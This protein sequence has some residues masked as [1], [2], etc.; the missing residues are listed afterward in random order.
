MLKKSMYQ[1][2]LERIGDVVNS[3]QSISD[4]E[5][6]E[7]K[8]D[9]LLN[10]SYE[11]IEN[12]TEIIS[13]VKAAAMTKA[14]DIHDTKAGFVYDLEALGHKV[15]VETGAF[16]RSASTDYESILDFLAK[17]PMITEELIN[18]ISD[19]KAA[20]AKY[21]DSLQDQGDAADEPAETF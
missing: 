14:P 6:E 19:A 4:E 16:W 17:T 10:E 8:A 13:I 15:L 2:V 11:A 1:E 9:E 18:S 3:I 21:Y 20:V 7:I 5:D 12:F